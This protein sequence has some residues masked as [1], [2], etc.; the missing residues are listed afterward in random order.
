[1]IT[2][3]ICEGQMEKDDLFKF[4]LCIKHLNLKSSFENKIFSV[5]YFLEFEFI[6]EKKFKSYFNDEI[7]I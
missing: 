3:Q 5:S 7:Y 2:H 1:M 4:T 6:D